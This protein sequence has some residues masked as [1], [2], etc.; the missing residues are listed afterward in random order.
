MN[1]SVTVVGG[2]LFRLALTTLGDA[3]QWS[4]IAALNRL[5]DPVLMGLQV[6]AIPARDRSA[7]GGL[8]RD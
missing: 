6:L 2:D 7:G 3:T 4:R 5:S 8:R 1:T